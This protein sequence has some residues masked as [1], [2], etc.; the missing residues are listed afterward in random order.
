[1]VSGRD[2]IGLAGHRPIIDL[3]RITQALVAI[4]CT[5]Q[6]WTR[7]SDSMDDDCDDDETEMRSLRKTAAGS[8]GVSRC[9]LTVPSVGITVTVSPPSPDCSPGRHPP[10]TDQPIGMYRHRLSVNH[11]KFIVLFEKDF[12]TSPST[13]RMSFILNTSTASQRHPAPVALDSGMK[14]FVVVVTLLLIGSL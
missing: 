4:T 6:V 3:I 11:S 8:A 13:I 1:M 10:F 12:R 7:D 2:H 14:F 9:N 5:I